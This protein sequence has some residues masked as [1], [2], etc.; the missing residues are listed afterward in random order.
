[1]ANKNKKGAGRKP[2][3]KNKKPAGVRITP[4]VRA[5]TKAW[6]NEQELSQGKM[7]DLL[8]V[9]KNKTSTEE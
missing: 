3:S 9:E 8:V 7:I 2:G 1:M 5:E 6:L 4:T